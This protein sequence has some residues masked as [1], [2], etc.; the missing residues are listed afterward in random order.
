MERVAQG[1]LSA[2]PPPPATL[3]LTLYLCSG[4]PV[5][6]LW[7]STSREARWPTRCTSPRCRAVPSRA[8]PRHAVPALSIA[9]TPSLPFLFAVPRFS[10]INNGTGLHYFPTGMS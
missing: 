1:C 9:H 6:S 8:T 3:H 4:G 5:D 2:A 10:V 7:T